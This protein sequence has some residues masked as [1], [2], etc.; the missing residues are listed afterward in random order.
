M[1]EIRGLIFTNILAP[2]GS[3]KKPYE[4]VFEMGKLTEACE[5]SLSQYNM[6]SDKPMDLVLF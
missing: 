5:E 1:D 6:V 2:I 4:E 3:P